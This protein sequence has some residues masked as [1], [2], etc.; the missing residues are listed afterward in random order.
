[1]CQEGTNE[2]FKSALIDFVAHYQLG[3]PTDT[4]IQDIDSH[5]L[6]FQ[7][8]GYFAEISHISRH[9]QRQRAK[10]R[11]GFDEI[12]PQPLDHA[13]M[14]NR[15]ALEKLAC[16]AA[17]DLEAREKLE[18]SCGRKWYKC[19]KAACYYFHEG[20]LDEKSREYHAVR[21][22]Q[23]FRCRYMDCESGYK[24]GFTTM[25]QLEN[26]LSVH[27]PECTKIKA[28]FARLRKD[29]EQGNDS[30]KQAT[31]TSKHPAKFSCHICSKVY[32]RREKLNNHLR[33][34]SDERVLVKCSIAGC[35]KSF[36]RDDERKRHEKEVHSGEKRFS[37]TGNLKYG[38]PG[39]NVYGCG[40]AFPRLSA[41]ASHWR[42]NAGQACLK[43]LR[44]EEERERQWQDQIAKRKAE[45]LE[46]P[47]P[48]QL[49]DQF[50]E[51]RRSISEGP[52]LTATGAEG[53]S[54]INP[55]HKKWQPFKPSPT[56][57]AASSQASA[58]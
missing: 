45:G 7:E 55:E 42:S 32:T 3:V 53:Q 33:T 46:L 50:P 57:E 26:H 8:L 14:S 38:I 23:P 21:H 10:G 41:L 51:L 56:P 34:H 27:H 12:T 16:S 28:I 9:I 30:P 13:I 15:A 1:L 18:Q 48:R 47:L 6:Q 22:E 58:G 43:P 40:K 54:F 19:T 4:E 52:S 37:C 44:D 5:C 24:L 49:Y 39:S 20:F 17:L 35:G 25:K 29:R 11:Q 36:A 31:S 2:S